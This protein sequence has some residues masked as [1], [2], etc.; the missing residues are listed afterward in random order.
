MRSSRA[1]AFAAACT[2]GAARADEVDATA[3]TLIAGHADPRDGQIHTVVPIYELVG[4]RASVDSAWVHDLHLVVS[5]WGEVALGDPREGRLDGDLDLGYLEGTVFGDH[6]TLRLG[7]QLVA[8][9]AARVTPLDGASVTGRLG[10]GRLRFGATAYAG[11]PV[12]PRFAVSR[13]DFAAGGRVFWRPAFATEVGLS[14]IDVL[15]GGRAAREDGA[16]DARWSPHPAVALAGLA[17]VS[18]RELRLAQADA[19]VTVRPATWV[20]FAAGWQRTAPDLFLP[21]TS[22]LSVFSQETRDEVGGDLALYVDRRLQLVGDYHAI[23]EEAGWGQRGGG[24]ARVRLGG[25]RQTTVGAEV[26][27]LLLPEQGY[28]RARLWGSHAVT[29]WALVTLDLDGYRLTQPLNGETFSFTAS[30]SLAFR[31]AA[32]WRLVLAGFADENPLVERRFELLAKLVWEQPFPL[33]RKV[34]R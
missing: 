17:L 4:A 2:I 8:G 26:H 7:R 3:T 29:D 25:E 19:N 13:G 9:G 30:G 23:H 33:R 14:F 10:R 27:V 12:A 18:F 32:A 31:L 21:A 22:I 5:G 24:G 15:G 1:I 11:A 6:L 28:Y 16:I 20:D 34:S